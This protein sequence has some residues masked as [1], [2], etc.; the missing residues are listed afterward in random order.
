MLCHSS[1]YNNN[2][3]INFT[4]REFISIVFLSGVIFMPR[5]PL[6]FNY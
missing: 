1:M 4:G 2:I 5:N 3:I 6:Y